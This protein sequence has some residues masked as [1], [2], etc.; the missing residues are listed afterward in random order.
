M[1][2]THGLVATHDGHAIHQRQPGFELTPMSLGKIASYVVVAPDTTYAVCAFFYSMLDA[3]D[4]QPLDEPLLLDSAVRAIET[5][6]DAHRIIPGHE[7]TFVYKGGGFV[8]VNDPK[9]W[10]ARGQ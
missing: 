1:L 8:E 4:G 6:I 10:V 3:L 5:S 7:H 9:W 2:P